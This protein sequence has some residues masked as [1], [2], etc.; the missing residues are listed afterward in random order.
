MMQI[1]TTTIIEWPVA[2]GL[3]LVACGLWLVAC[4]CSEEIQY[5]RE[6]SQVLSAFEAEG[7]FGMLV[8][9]YRLC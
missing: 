6:L 3:W 1:P 4:G 9:Q 2:C 7:Q 8:L 5:E